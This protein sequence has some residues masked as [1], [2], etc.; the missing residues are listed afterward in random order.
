MLKNI[1]L[2]GEFVN[3]KMMKITTENHKLSLL[4]D[5][6]RLETEKKKILSYNFNSFFP[7]R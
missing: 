2:K 6:P 7:L 1:K 5:D 3:R 4:G